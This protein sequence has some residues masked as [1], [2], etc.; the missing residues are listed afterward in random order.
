MAEELLT[1]F[2]ANLTWPEAFAIASAVFAIILGISGY[3]LKNF[4]TKKEVSEE[5]KL[6]SMET[7]NDARFKGIEKDIEIIEKNVRELRAEVE[8]HDQRDQRDFKSLEGKIDQLNNLF[9]EF[10]QSQINK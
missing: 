4:V 7:T 9:I 2:G 5:S 6:Q 3:I 1:F 10:L 8:K